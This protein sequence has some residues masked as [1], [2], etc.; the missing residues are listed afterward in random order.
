[1]E[2]FARV[3]NRNKDKL[4]QRPEGSVGGGPLAEDCTMR[5]HWTSEK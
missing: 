5:N 4:N 2:R 3:M 1:M